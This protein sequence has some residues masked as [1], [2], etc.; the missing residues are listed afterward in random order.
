MVIGLWSQRFQEIMPFGWMKRGDGHGSGRGAVVVFP[1]FWVDAGALD[2]SPRLPHPTPVISQP[3]AAPTPAAV[4]LTCM[5][6]E[7]CSIP[8][9]GVLE[10]DDLGGAFMCL[11]SHQT[12]FKW[13]CPIELSV[14]T[15][16]SHAVLSNVGATGH[17]WPWSTWNLHS[18][19]ETL[20]F[21]FYPSKCSFK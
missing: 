14:M 7:S 4:P 16:T 13:R 3:C 20:T 12:S 9:S 6:C 21:K 1:S 5:A 11:P 18:V 15:E 19:T 17:M 10:T 2:P 8:S